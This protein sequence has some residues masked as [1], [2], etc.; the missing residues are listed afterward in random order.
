MNRLTLLPD[1]IYKQVYCYVF[2]PK[3]NIPKITRHTK[4]MLCNENKDTLIHICSLC[5]PFMSYTNQPDTYCNNS[6]IC[7]NCISA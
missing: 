2:S 4:C 1:E 7:L 3:I 6:Y 5:K